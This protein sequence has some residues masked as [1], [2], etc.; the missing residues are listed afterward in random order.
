MSEVTPPP[1]DLPSPAGPGPQF[2]TEPSAVPPSVPVGAPAEPSTT[3]PPLPA[4]PSDPATPGPPP[5]FV[6]PTGAQVPFG[7]LRTDAVGPVYAGFWRRAWAR[8]ISILV[9]LVAMSIGTFAINALT[10]FLYDAAKVDAILVAGL[11]IDWAYGLTLAYLLFS[12]SL[13]RH[14]ATIGMRQMG[15]TIV[16][17]RTLGPISKGRAFRRSFVAL[18]PFVF[19]SAASWIVLFNPTSSVVALVSVVGLV[20]SLLIVL[21]GLWMLV[22]DRRQTVWDIVGETVVLVEHEPSWLAVAE[23]V[24]G[25]MVPVAAGFT[26]VVIGVDRLQSE[27]QRLSGAGNAGRYLLY[28]VPAFL[29]ALVAIVLGHVAVRSTRWEK[30]RLAGGG[31]ARTGLVLGYA[32]PVVVLLVVSFG[33][34]YRRVEDR[35]A[36]S[37]A[38]E[39]TAIVEAITSF[40][41]LNGRYPTDVGQVS[42]SIYV[43]DTS[44]EPNWTIDADNDVVPPAYRLIGKERCAKA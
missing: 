6:Q 26:L 24:V 36:R 10:L 32:F 9:W 7:T 19:Y 28:S 42:G 15:L 31:L 11:A 14:G 3:P 18:I 20:L 34:L 23:F 29:V 5:M 44:I 22:S 39:R 35:Q 40:Q 27:Y 17:E 25:L 1:G 12:R 8:G 2:W 37:C 13:A 21:G 16:L 41:R 30:N 38:E 33:V 4:A 43:N